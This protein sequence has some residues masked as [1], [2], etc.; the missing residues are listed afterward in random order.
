MCKYVQFLAYLIFVYINM[1]ILV[2][3]YKIVG[4]LTPSKLHLNGLNTKQ[5]V[6][7]CLPFSF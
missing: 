4:R 5:R 6:T 1:Y 2:L 3:L 7:D